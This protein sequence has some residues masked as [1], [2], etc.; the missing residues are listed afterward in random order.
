MIL[1][2][3]EPL[4]GYIFHYVVTMLH[5]IPKLFQ[6][7]PRFTSFVAVHENMHQITARGQSSTAERK[8]KVI[9]LAKEWSARLW[10]C[11]IFHKSNCKFFHQALPSMNT[12]FSFPFFSILPTQSLQS[13]KVHRLLEYLSLKPYDSFHTLKMH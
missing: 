5:Y 3:S 4:F 12:K 11:S 6:K 1:E 13:M 9:V 10:K 7:A 8:I 2:E